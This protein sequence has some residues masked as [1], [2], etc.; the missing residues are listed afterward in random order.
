MR[1]AIIAGE[2]QLVRGRQVEDAIGPRRVPLPT[3][4]QGVGR[5]KLIGGGEK[6][7][8]LL[9]PGEHVS[10]SA[11]LELVLVKELVEQIVLHDFK[12]AVPLAVEPVV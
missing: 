10:F 1:V 7:L 2:L 9:E 3:E 12:D 5:L 8:S 6:H 4:S 11:H